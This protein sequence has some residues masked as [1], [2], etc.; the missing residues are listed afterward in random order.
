MQD[1]VAATRHSPIKASY[2]PSSIQKKISFRHKLSFSIEA[3]YI[4]VII[5]DYYYT[6]NLGGGLLF[7]LHEE[8]YFRWAQI[9]M[10]K[11][12]CK[13]KQLLMHYFI[14][15]ESTLKMEVNTSKFLMPWEHHVCSACLQRNPHAIWLV[16]CRCFEPQ[17]HRGEEQ[18]LVI[19]DHA[20]MVMVR[21]RPLP[22]HLSHFRGEFMECRNYPNCYHN[23]ECKFAHSKAE[24]DTWNIKKRILGGRSQ[25]RS[26]LAKT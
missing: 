21:I 11:Q 26:Q 8:Q 15:L 19:I 13:Q 20:C 25:L 10:A 23:T 16:K 2:R 1:S 14:L 18:V 22:H 5:L 6:S 7:V 3:L 4:E 12:K 17:Q 9:S 24:C